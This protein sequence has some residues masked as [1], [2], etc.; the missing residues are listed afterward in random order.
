MLVPASSEVCDGSGANWFLHWAVRALVHR[1]LPRGL[2]RWE[3]AGK[4]PWAPILPLFRVT[5]LLTTLWTAVGGRPSTAR[6]LSITA[7]LLGCREEEGS[8]FPLL[9]AASRSSL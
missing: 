6:C 1:V 9:A 8:R 7:L 4:A 3:A 2:W 5:P